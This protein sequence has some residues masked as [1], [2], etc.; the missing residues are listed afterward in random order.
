MSIKCTQLKRTLKQRIEAL[1]KAACSSPGTLATGDE[2]RFQPC[3][4]P[5]NNNPKP[6]LS[7]RVPPGA[8]G[9]AYDRVNRRFVVSFNGATDK[10]IGKVVGAGLAL[11]DRVLFVDVPNFVGECAV[12]EAQ[13]V[14]TCF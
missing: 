3:D 11:E 14:F 12:H 5:A 7:I 10:N 4:G 2:G 9:I 1:A 8:T 13:L 6:I